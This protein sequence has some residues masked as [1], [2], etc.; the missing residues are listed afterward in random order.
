MNEIHEHADRD[1][2]D[3]KV[4]KLFQYG[5]ISCWPRSLLVGRTGI[6]LDEMAMAEVAISCRLYGVGVDKMRIIEVAI[7]RRNWFGRNG[8]YQTLSL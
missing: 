8:Y 1:R 2:S 7:S 6:S 3:I 5:Q 4:S